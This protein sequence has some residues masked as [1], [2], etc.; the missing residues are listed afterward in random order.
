MVY[1]DYVW[2]FVACFNSSGHPTLPIPLGLGKEGL[3]L[4]IQIVGPRSPTDL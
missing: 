1:A 4:G 2:P 3:P